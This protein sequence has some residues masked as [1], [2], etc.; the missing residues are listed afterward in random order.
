LSQNN[1]KP[2]GQQKS[3]RGWYFQRRRPDETKK[4]Q[5]THVEEGLENMMARAFV[6]EVTIDAI[7]SLASSLEADGTP[8]EVVD[9]A[10]GMYLSDIMASRFSGNIGDR[11]PIS[12]KEVFAKERL[13]KKYETYLNDP[14]F[15]PSHPYTQKLLRFCRLVVHNHI[16]R[17]T[18]S[19]ALEFRPVVPWDI[20]TKG[21][22][23]NIPKKDALETD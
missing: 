21:P 12:P 18:P 4:R 16:T 2:N 1:G 15:G 9:G 3:P 7:K 6:N 22:G 20:M 23:Q 13:I 14:D 11:Q 8:S 10:L 19:K 5:D 17:G